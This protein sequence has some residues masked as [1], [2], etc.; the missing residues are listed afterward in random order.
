MAD[1]KN[2]TIKIIGVPMDLGAS[3][4]G[5]DMG[6]SALRIAGLGDKLRQLGLEVGREEDIAVPAMETRSAE[7]SEARYKP[8]ILEVCTQLAHRTREIMDQGDFPLVLGGDHSIAMGTVAGVAAHYREKSESIGLLW[9]D[10]HGEKLLLPLVSP[11][12]SKPML[13]HP[14]GWVLQLSPSEMI[15][16]WK[17]TSCGSPLLLTFS[18]T[19]QLI[20][21]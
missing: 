13:W 3:R 4:R 18:S 2:K 17:V 1:I 9:F 16:H 11:P 15:D 21:Q 12:I 14:L 6:P 5:T 20:E 8:Q 19:A 7:D 10:A